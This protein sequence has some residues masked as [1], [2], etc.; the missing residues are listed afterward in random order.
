[1]VIHHLA[2]G[3]Y[4]IAKLCYLPGIHEPGP[5]QSLTIN[6]AAYDGLTDDL[7]EIVKV[8]ATNGTMQLY[9]ENVYHNA[10][11]V[12]TLRKKGAQF[13]MLPEDVIKSFLKISL[14]VLYDTASKDAHAMKVYESYMDFRKRALP[15]S[16]NDM[17]PYLLA[18]STQA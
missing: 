9:S 11:S 18:R 16:E 5:N 3:F 8:A 6:T 1:M 13:K 7:K 10:D 2:F 15:A 12:E 4:K 14:D 17:L